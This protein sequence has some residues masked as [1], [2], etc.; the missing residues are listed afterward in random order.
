V[1]NKKPQQPQ[2]PQ[3]PKE[4]VNLHTKVLKSKMEKQLDRMDFEKPSAQDG[5]GLFSHH[6]HHLDKC[7]KIESCTTAHNPKR[8]AKP[9]EPRRKS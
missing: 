1:E 9:K 4:L 6:Q 7:E 5:F 8:F 2:K 3:V